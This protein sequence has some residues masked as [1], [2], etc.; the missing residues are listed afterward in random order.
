MN[1]LSMFY[2]RKEHK[3]QINI[4]SFGYKRSIVN[5]QKYAHS[6]EI[7]TIFILWIEFLRGC[8]FVNTRDMRLLFNFSFC[9]FQLVGTSMSPVFDDFNKLELKI[10]SFFLFK[11]VI[12]NWFGFWKRRRQTINI[13][14]KNQILKPWRILSLEQRNSRKMAQIRFINRKNLFETMEYKSLFWELFNY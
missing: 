2:D 5:S 8:V 10:W 11:F 14:N 6:I 13:T 1:T 3:K 12:R 7:L 4:L 9:H